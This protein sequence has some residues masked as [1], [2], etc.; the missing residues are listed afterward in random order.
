[1]KVAGRKIPKGTVLLFL[2]FT[3]ISLCL[4]L[5]LTASRAEQTNS[6][7][8][9]GMYSGHQKNFS[10]YNSEQEGLWEEVMPV[11]GAK[12]DDFAIYMPLQDPEMIVRGVCVRGKV[13]EPPML[14]G[15]YFDFADS[16]SDTPK[17][18]LGKQYREMAVERDGKRYC[19]YQ[20]MEFEVAG[21]MGTK[22]DSRL[23]YMMLMDLRSAVR[24][25]GINSS[26]VLDTKKEADL[27][28]IGQE[29]NSLFPLPAQVQILLEAG[30][31][32]SPIA[33]LLS[34]GALMD[35][36]YVMI[37]I[38][39]SLSTILVTLIWLRFRRQIIY[40]WQLCGYEGRMQRLEISKHFFLAAGAGFAAGFLLAVL[41][42][43]ILED[44]RMGAADI[45]QA[46]GMT[47]GL[48]AVILFLCYALDRMAKSY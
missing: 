5:I 27:L 41:L 43:F 22:E 36:M 6:M 29:L 7:S 33:R 15:K 48:G 28:E 35:T 31:V 14:E 37:L 32:V 44:I 47:V 17:A 45:L 24:I 30:D 38:S 40:V 8:K 1:M 16:W 21:V 25:A 23:N 2:S 19:T 46:F 11:L 26:Y 10:V 12:Y 4:L 39:F 42:S 34:G 13:E 20:G 9:N 3:A 18:V